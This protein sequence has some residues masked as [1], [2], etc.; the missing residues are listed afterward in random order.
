MQFTLTEENKPYKTLHS[1][2]LDRKSIHVCQC[3]LN[4]NCSLK[5]IHKASESPSKDL[6]MYLSCL[7]VHFFP[8]KTKT[9]GN[10]NWNIYMILWYILLI[11]YMSFHF[12]CPWK[13]I[14]YPAFY[15]NS[16]WETGMAYYKLKVRENFFFVVC[17][18]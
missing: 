9:T 13:N 10:E 7:S 17:F 8:L 12:T 2:Q 15:A 11:I 14:C 18:V 6:D 16:F 1:A 4:S 3:Y 5:T